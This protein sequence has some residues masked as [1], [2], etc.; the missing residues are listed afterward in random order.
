MNGK[1]LQI[2][3]IEKL[4]KLFVPDPHAAKRFI[5]FFNAN[6][7][8]ANTV[9]AHAHAAQEFGNWC[10]LNGFH[11][12]RDIEPVHIAAYT[13]KLQN[14]LGAFIEAAPGRHPHALQLARCGPGARR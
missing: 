13:E 3:W 1:S 7:R 6:I 12:L 4:P 10:E 2:L 9:K 8:N 5:E 14:P 11:E